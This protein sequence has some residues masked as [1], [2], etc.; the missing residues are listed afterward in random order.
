MNHT[1]GSTWRKW[2]LHIHTPASI[3]QNYGGDGAWDKFIESLEQLPSDIKVIGINDYYFI[4]GFEKVME[5]KANGRLQNLEKIF[6]V[7]EFRID[8]FGND[9]D[10]IKKVN[11]HILFDVDES[12][13]KNE[14]KKIKEQ[15]VLMVPI[16][17]SDKHT[18]YM[19][20]PENLANYGGGK[21]RDGWI[22]K[23]NFI[24]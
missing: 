5:Y 21:V 2:D 10:N 17:P 12:D 18:T 24:N 13:L 3:I 23:T 1:K 19:L 8:T 16:S 4:N 6:P 15:F 14:I 9:G 22:W 20:T 11:L 7:L